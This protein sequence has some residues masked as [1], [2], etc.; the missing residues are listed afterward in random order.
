MMMIITYMDIG[1]T[2]TNI[3]PDAVKELIS[4]GYLNKT[5]HD[6]ISINAHHLLSLGKYGL[7]I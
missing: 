2:F 3:F 4:Q 1:L 6:D 5:S 7:I